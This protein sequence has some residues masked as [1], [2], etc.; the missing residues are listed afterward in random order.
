MIDATFFLCKPYSFEGICKIYPPTVNE[1]LDNFKTDIYIK[2]LTMSQEDIID[3]LSQVDEQLFITPLQYMLFLASENEDVER[4]YKEAFQFF[5]R[6]EVTFLYKQGWIVIGNLEEELKKVKTISELRIL[7][8]QNFFDFQNKVREAVGTKPVDFFEFDADPRIRAMKAKARYRDKVKAKKGGLDLTTI[9][10]AICCMG[11][12]LTPLNIGEISYASV[13][14]LMET[15]GHKEK[16][17]IDIRSLL[18]GAD[19]KKVQPEYWIANFD[20]K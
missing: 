14:T 7:N 1:V 12:G 18:A 2:I 13:S 9:L 15:Y 8:E 3:E 6:E 11:I 4:L 10:A 17:D 5:I 19:S 20:K 16:Y